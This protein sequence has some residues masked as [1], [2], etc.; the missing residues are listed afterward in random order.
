M[1]VL[2]GALPD[3]EA[4]LAYERAAPGVEPSSAEGGNWPTKLMLT[5]SATVTLFGALELR[6]VAQVR[7]A[8][9]HQP[10]AAKAKAMCGPRVRYVPE[11][12]AG[13]LLP[14]RSRLRR[15]TI[16]S[17]VPYGFSLGHPIPMKQQSRRS[18]KKKDVCG[19]GYARMLQNKH[20][21]AS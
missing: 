17:S 1:T 11:S 13:T 14:D 10:K 5:S 8:K 21:P 20:R 6:K 18:L 4:G 12:V 7:K 3:G 9:R 2:L 15:M 16:A 19:V